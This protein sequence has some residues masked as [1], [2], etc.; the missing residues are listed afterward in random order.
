M[1]VRTYV[2]DM[3]TTTCCSAGLA[4]VTHSLFTH[5][6]FLSCFLS[7]NSISSSR[8]R[9]E[10]LHPPADKKPTKVIQ[11]GGSII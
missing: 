4:A 5:P 6:A 8:R 10:G 3:Y 9:S 7:L 1:Y 11:E 2:H